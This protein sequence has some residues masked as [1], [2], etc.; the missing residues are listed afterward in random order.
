MKVSVIIPVRNEERYIKECLE[1]LLC[2]DYP[3]DKLEIIFVDGRSDD[4]TRDIIQEYVAK[5]P[6]IRLLDNPK[7][8]VP[9]A[10]NIGITNSTG[11]IIVR[12]DAHAR[13][14]KDYISK[15]V[16][17]S[18]KTGADNVGGPMRAVGT[19][20]IGKAIEIAHHSIFGLG[21]GK[22][23]DETYTGNVDTVYLGAFRRD[24]FERVGLY[25]ERLVRNQDIEL[26]SRIRAAGG[27]C[28]L[29][30]EIRVKYYCRSSLCALWRQNFSNGLW[31]IYTYW[32]S[33]GA[34][35]IRHFVPLV[36]VV[37]LLVSGFVAVL[38]SIM[39]TGPLALMSIIPFLVVIGS[40]LIASFCFSF[41]AARKYGLKYLLVLPIV[42]AVLHFS[43]GLGSIVGVLTFRKWLKKQHNY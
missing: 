17:W 42:F 21:G 39:L 13:Y 4:R 5:Y 40:Y 16:E 24:V 27:R 8:I 3:Q 15:C 12:M 19:D 36:F 11:D 35:S 30:P 22:F 7:K 10:M 41:A 33:K 26:N 25:D 38:G 32:V 1:S 20:S 34:L 28:F 43:Y 6:F 37:S 2:Q 23:H 9:T 14:A 29:T 18:E 31:S